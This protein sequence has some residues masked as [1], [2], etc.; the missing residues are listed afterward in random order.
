MVP[1]A[2]PTAKTMIVPQGINFSTD[3]QSNTP[4]FGESKIAIAIIVTVVV[5]N[6]CNFDSVAQKK[7]SATET[8]IR[9]SS[10]FFKGPKSFNCCLVISLLP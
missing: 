8:I 4:I 2:I 9:R 10:S 1:R 3:F 7:R 6:G 5:S